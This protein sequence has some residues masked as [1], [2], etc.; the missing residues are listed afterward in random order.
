MIGHCVQLL[1][2]MAQR[3]SYRHTQIFLKLVVYI[4]L[5]PLWGFMFCKANG[6]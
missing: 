4:L 5:S 6:A 1:E 3:L 2:K